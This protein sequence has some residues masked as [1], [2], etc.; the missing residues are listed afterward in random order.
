MSDNTPI[1]IYVIKIENSISFKIK[2]GY[3]LIMPEMM[4]L[5]GSTER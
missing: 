1:R 3:Y 2:T 4:K 5:L